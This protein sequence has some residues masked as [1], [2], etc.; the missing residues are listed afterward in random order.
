MAESKVDYSQL[1]GFLFLMAAFVSFLF[2]SPSTEEEI[3]I[4]VEESVRINDSPKIYQDF[5]ENETEFTD[6][7]IK[8]E[9]ES[10]II[11][12]ENVILKFSNKGAKISELTLKD[13]NDSSGGLVRVLEN[14]QSLGLSFFNMN[15]VL[16]DSNS[17]MFNYKS[18]DN[19]NSKVVEFEYL[20]N[21]G[22]K[23]YS[24]M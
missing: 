13:Y 18:F 20:N 3:D 9:E 21:L 5:R 12:N 14:N 15:G 7:I 19:Q 2:I 10:F 11:E 23:Y 6:N 22:G 16:F 1:M 4:Q 17:V 8:I 24:D